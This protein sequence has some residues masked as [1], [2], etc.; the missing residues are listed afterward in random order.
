M[1]GGMEGERWIGNSHQAPA[2]TT[3]NRPVFTRP[4]FLFAPFAGHPSSSPFLDTF[5]P[6]SPP[7][8]VLCSVEQRAQHKAW[9][10][11]VWGWTPPQSSGRKFLPEICVKKGPQIGR[12]LDCKSSSLSSVKEKIGF[13]HEAYRS[14]AFLLLIKNF[15]FLDFGPQHPLKLPEI[16]WNCLKLPENAWNH[17]KIAQTN[18]LKSPDE[19]A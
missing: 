17:L 13:R 5:S 8:K 11:A 1:Q 4:F 3:P 7:R 18:C 16:A 6:F 10:G 14:P 2:E 9:R 12:E 15:F 19:I